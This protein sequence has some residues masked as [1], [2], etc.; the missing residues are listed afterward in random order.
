MD[1]VDLKWYTY[2]YAKDGIFYKAIL[3]AYLLLFNQINIIAPNYILFGI[4]MEE[5]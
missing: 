5:D 2:I 3:F 4:R 1:K